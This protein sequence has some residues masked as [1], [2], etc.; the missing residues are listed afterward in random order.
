MKC[1]HCTQGIHE[2]WQV[3]GNTTFEDVDAQWAILLMTCP[4]CSRII[5]RLHNRSTGELQLLRPRA[6]ARAALSPDVPEAFAADYR[7]ACLVLADSPKASAA[8][9][10][11]CLQQLLREK[12]GAK[13]GNLSDEIMEA[14]QGLPP[15]LAKAVDAV[16]NIGNFS[17][18]PTK[19][20]STGEIVDVEPGEADWCLE[21]LEGLFDFYFVQPAVLQR[22]RDALNQKLQEAGKPPMK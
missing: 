16:R 22:K 4:E 12:G 6:P 5:L 1:P 15:H 21:V 17:A 3:F 2:G 9:S 18:H 7:E 20:T 11:R 14:M 13:P 8:L 19:S 10:R